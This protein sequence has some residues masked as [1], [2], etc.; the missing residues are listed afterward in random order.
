VPAPINR[1]IIA[2]LALLSSAV[3]SAQWPTQADMDR[4]RKA[5]PLPDAGRMG[6]QAIPVPPRIDLTRPGLDIEALAR[7]GRAVPGTASAA[8]AE[9]NTLRI[10]V[11]LAMPRASLDL[12]TEQAARSGAVLV[13]RGLKAQ[14]MRETLATVGDLIGTRAVAWTIDPEAFSRFGI[15][16]APTFVLAL[17][18][19]AAQEACGAAGCVTPSS[20]VK[21][22]GDVSLAYAL[23]AMMRR[24]PE[25]APRVEPLLKRLRGS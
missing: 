9:A 19:S 10:F 12:L 18:D 24:R 22:A 5:R 3:A 7:Q 2:A 16:K 15:D 8:S 14:S 25:T 13:L 1:I 6:A 20:F 21:V 4:A 17:T 23:E 11:T